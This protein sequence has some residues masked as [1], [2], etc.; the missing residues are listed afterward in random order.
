MPNA[1]RWSSM[2]DMMQRSSELHA[3]AR[4]IEDV[5]DTL[6]SSNNH[7]KLIEVLVD[8][9]KM[10]S[11]YAVR[12]NKYGIVHSSAFESGVVKVCG[13]ARLTPGEATALKQFERLHEQ[14]AQ[15]AATGKRKKRADDYASQII[16][17]GGN[18][19]SKNNTA[20][21]TA[22]AALV[23]PTSNTCERLFSEYKVVLTPRRSSLL[24][25]HFET[26]LF[27]RV[28]KDLGDVTSMT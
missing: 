15:C 6:P 21:Y 19:K 11:V 7:K 23:P 28:N 27:L 8:L 9:R 2:Y 4:L 1:T 24:P 20:S 25:A 16:R 5:E 14:D 17:Q 10:K 3:H 12:G 26:L 22:L 18:K 13:D